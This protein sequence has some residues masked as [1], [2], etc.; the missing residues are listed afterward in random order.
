MDS[1]VV[2]EVLKPNGIKGEIKVYPLTDSAQRFKKL[3]KYF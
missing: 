1:V 2:G 3:K